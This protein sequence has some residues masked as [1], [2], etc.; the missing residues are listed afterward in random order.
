MVC[1]V[2]GLPK[3]WVLF[4]GLPTLRTIVFWGLYWGS[5]TSG[6]YHVTPGICGLGVSDQVSPPPSGAARFARVWGRA[7][8]EWSS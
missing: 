1:R 8:E 4:S 3:L 6:N 5:P 7:A 2:E